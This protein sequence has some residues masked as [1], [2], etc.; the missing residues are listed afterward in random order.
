[1]EVD[2]NVIKMI[3]KKEMTAMLV[4]ISH[5]G[6]YGYR[7][8]G[9]IRFVSG[10]KYVVVKILGITHH[11]DFRGA[12]YSHGSCFGKNLGDATTF[13]RYYNNIYH[14]PDEDVNALEDRMSSQYIRDMGGCMSL[15]FYVVEHNPNDYT[16]LIEE[17]YI[18]GY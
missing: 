2:E 6:I 14:Y 11:F 3:V 16:S 10:N 13:V 8:G 18:F 5:I 1:M 12:F 7:L 4:P 9:I 15:I 17:E